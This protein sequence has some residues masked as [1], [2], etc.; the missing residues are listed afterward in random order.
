MNVLFPSTELGQDTK[1][2]FNT[3]AAAA[4]AHFALSRGCPGPWEGGRRD[5]V[6]Y[7]DRLQVL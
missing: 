5:S 4:A 6:V 2:E 1:R 3:T 7:V